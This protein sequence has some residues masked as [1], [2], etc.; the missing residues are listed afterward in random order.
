MLI[1]WILNHD[2]DD[3]KDQLLGGGFKNTKKMDVYIEM[4]SYMMTMT[5]K[6]FFGWQKKNTNT[7]NQQTNKQ[8]NIVCNKNYNN[9]KDDFTLIP[10]IV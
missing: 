5:I 8:T 7:T 1:L 2:D 3:G 4:K 6:Y 9:K 10:L